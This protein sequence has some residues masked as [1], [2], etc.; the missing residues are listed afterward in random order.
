MKKSA[1]TLV[2]LLLVIGIISIL[3]AMLLGAVFKAQ[4]YARHKTL[5]FTAYDSIYRM[6]EQLFRFYGKQTNYPAYTAVQLEQKGVFDLHTES[7]L[8]NPE[9]TFYPFS[10]ADPDGKIILKAVVRTN[11]IYWLSKSNATHAPD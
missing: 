3:A 4:R 2:E 6:Q 1:Y 11:E 7:F 8:D 5:E 10:S 9:V